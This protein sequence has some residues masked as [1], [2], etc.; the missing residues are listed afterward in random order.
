VLLHSRESAAASDAR[1]D[2][3]QLGYFRRT[4]PSKSQ[5]A[6]VRRE[7]KSV[8]SRLLNRSYLSTTQR[9]LLGVCL[10]SPRGRRLF[11]FFQ[12]YM[13]IIKILFCPII[14]LFGSCI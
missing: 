10:L 3:A 6:S 7:R 11:C 14:V 5:Q 12:S 4:W 9:Y 1:V 8:C 13:E 2:S